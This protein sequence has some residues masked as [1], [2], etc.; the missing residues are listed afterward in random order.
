MK[1]FKALLILI[2]FTVTFV[3]CKK[4][5]PGSEP[6]TL[7]G[8]WEQIDQ[9]VEEYEN[10][11]LVYSFRE[12]AVEGNYTETIVFTEADFTSYTKSW[13]DDTIYLDTF[14]SQYRLDGDLFI[15]YDASSNDTLNYSLNEDDFKIY[16]EYLDFD[17]S[18][19][20]TNREYVEVNY[21]RK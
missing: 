8:S 1:N 11:T 9:L 20:T 17:S 14:T 3:G 2:A 5:E 4:D 16:T 21:K 19:N 6:K 15:Y 7:V 10:D 13:V 18:S 12:A